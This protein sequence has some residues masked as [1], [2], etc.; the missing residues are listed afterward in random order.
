MAGTTVQVR[1]VGR[2]GGEIDTLRLEFNKLVLD[3]ETV[4]SAVNTAN[5]GA[6]NITEASLT[7]GLI[8]ATV[9]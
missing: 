4:R 7:A 3:I 2:P 6:I 8:S 9:G 1:S 5:G